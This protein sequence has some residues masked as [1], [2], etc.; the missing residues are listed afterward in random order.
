MAGLKLYRS[1][2]IKQVR[3][4]GGMHR[5][6][7]AWVASVVPS[8]RIGECVVTHHARQ[9]GESKYGI[10]RTIRVFLD[11]LSLLFF[12]RFKQRPGHFFGTIGLVI[13]A[14]SSFI[15]LYLA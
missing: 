1:E 6:I 4:L 7:P 13:G 11:L 12:M 15:L 8:S 3:I 14:I 2:V 10:S 5:F 9:F